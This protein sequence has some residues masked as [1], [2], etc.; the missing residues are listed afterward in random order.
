MRSKRFTDA[1]VEKLKIMYGSLT[2]YKGEYLVSCGNTKRLVCN[3]GMLSEEIH[4]LKSVYKDLAIVDK[5][6]I[7]SMKTGRVLDLYGDWYA[8]VNVNI[9]AA[10]GDYYII[11]YTDFNANALAMEVTKSIIPGIKFS[12]VG[13]ISASNLKIINKEINN[14]NQFL[15]RVECTDKTIK[16]IVYTPLG[17]L[18][19]IEVKYNGIDKIEHNDRGADEVERIE[20]IVN[21]AFL[22]KLNINTGHMQ[23][24]STCEK[25]LKMLLRNK[26]D[27]RSNHSLAFTMALCAIMYIKKKLYDT[28]YSMELR[29]N[30]TNAVYDI[31]EQILENGLVE[32]Y[33]K[34]LTQYKNSKYTKEII[35]A[36]INK[37]GDKEIKI[38]G[39]AAGLNIIRSLTRLLREEE[40]Y[41]I[42]RQ[43]KYTGSIINKFRS[44]FKRDLDR[45]RNERSS[46]KLSYNFYA[47][48]YD[49]LFCVHTVCNTDE[50]Y[51]SG[52]HI[53]KLVVKE[54]IMNGEIRN[55]KYFGIIYNIEIDDDKLNSI[56]SYIDKIINNIGSVT[57]YERSSTE[58]DYVDTKAFNIWRGGRII[59]ESEL[60]II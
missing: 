29:D 50:L 8:N 6:N 32:Y 9:V 43:N 33:K 36:L 46:S 41:I 60:H 10:I 30:Y 55:S 27:L 49:E 7:L 20:D 23:M 35:K 22:S 58:T 38:E 40:D 44:S 25:E 52:V 14:M 16:A 51:N 48:I 24:F 28:D 2:Y 56:R 26:I 39:V 34:R 5:G 47:G 42:W 3:N 4:S 1:Q 13:I 57:I 17:G 21:I 12:R 15:A 59:K 31:V 53:A 11:E 37:T 45:I 19:T 18:G 54:Y